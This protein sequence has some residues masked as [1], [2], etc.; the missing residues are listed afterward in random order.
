MRMKVNKERE[1]MR[2]QVKKKQEREREAWSLCTNMCL[3]ERERDGVRV[4]QRKLRNVNKGQV[5][6]ESLMQGD[7]N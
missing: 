4:M 6:I 7:A 5:S 2:L 3:R 1:R